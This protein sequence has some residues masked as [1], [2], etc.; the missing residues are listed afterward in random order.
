MSLYLVTGNP[1][2]VTP[3]VTGTHLATRRRRAYP[4][5][6]SDAEWQIL[7][8]LVPVG[9]P[10]P[11]RGGRPV[12]YP[13]RDV[14][15]AIRYLDHNGCVWR[16][17]PVDFPPRSLVTHYFTAWARDCALARI[18][19]TLREQ[20]RVAEGRTR[21]STRPRLRPGQARQRAQA[22]HRRR[23]HRATFGRP[24]HRRRYPGPPG[25]HHADLGR[26]RLPGHPGR[27][28]DRSRGHPADRAQAHRPGR[29][30]RPTPQ[31]GRRDLSTRLRVSRW[32]G[33]VVAVVPF[34]S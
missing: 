17:L 9:G 19:D 21:R 34:E 33:G 15:D 25:R 5:D 24:G 7:A 8:P 28:D 3:H 22:P 31:V 1:A 20:I 27:L 16:A 26:R 23:H 14:V 13:R 32:V 6:T 18:H 29:V 30:R 12:T 2:T 4:S 11:G 10:V